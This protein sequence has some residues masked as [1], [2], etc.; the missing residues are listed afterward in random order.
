MSAAPKTF[1]NARQVTITYRDGIISV[2]QDPIELWS[3]NG[4]TLEWVPVPSNLEFTVCFDRE[5]PFYDR[6]FHHYKTQSGPINKGAT[7]RY[8][9][10]IEVDGKILDP[11]VLIRP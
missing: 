6:H 10:C 8:K 11:G 1:P 2:D 7:G 5:S 3:T 4:D 9:Y